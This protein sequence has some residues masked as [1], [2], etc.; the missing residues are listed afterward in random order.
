MKSFIASLCIAV[1]ALCMSVHA[2]PETAAQDALKGAIV[3]LSDCAAASQDKDLPTLIADLN[4]LL[5]NATPGILAT[6]EP[7]TNEQ[8]VTVIQA[9]MVSEEICK[10]AETSA[11]LSESKAAATVM[12]AV[13]GAADPMALT[14]E[15]SMQSKLQ[16]IDIVA[17]VAKIAI[18]LGVDTPAVLE[19]IMGGEEAACPA[20]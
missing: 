7:L 2:T 13:A 3:S 19:I 4:T 12:P 10:L 17:N 20:E 6:L 18:G 9:I 15:L 14:A 1:P 11:P 16:L 8:K 5:A